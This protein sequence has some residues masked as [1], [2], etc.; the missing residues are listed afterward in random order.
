[1][2]VVA[3]P[4][5]L[6]DACAIA[7]IGILAVLSA[8]A[9]PSAVKASAAELQRSSAAAPSET[10]LAAKLPACS[11]GNGSAGLLLYLERVMA[12]GEPANAAGCNARVLA[13]RSSPHL[14][15]AF[16]PLL[17][18]LEKT[19]QRTK[20]AAALTAFRELVD[21]KI[22]TLTRAARRIATDSNFG[23]AI[24]AATALLGPDGR[25]TPQADP[26]VVRLFRS[27]KAGRGKLMGLLRKKASRA[28]ARR[29]FF[30]Q[31]RALIRAATD[32]LGAE[33]LA[34][35]F[36]HIVRSD[37]IRGKGPLRKALRLHRVSA[38][39]AAEVVEAA[40]ELEAMHKDVAARE[41]ALT[42]PLTVAGLL[43]AVGEAQTR[44]GPSA[45][46]NEVRQYL[47]DGDGRL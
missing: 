38:A 44:A 42:R 39:V 30:A 29:S 10:E 21:G 14:A 36:W 43:K 12:A 6:K 25:F 7:L 18:A 2:T 9:D 23:E 11:A 37:G 27:G 8:C 24:A 33:G 47:E 46:L 34:I 3:L 19:G 5:P 15:Y 41:I 22:V 31:K 35:T 16:I 28:K 13:D 26:A 20:A 1:M 4:R 45:I 17:V 40:A 32:A